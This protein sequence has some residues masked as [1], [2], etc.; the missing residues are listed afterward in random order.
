[1]KPAHQAYGLSS[2]TMILG[3]TQRRLHFLRLTLVFFALVNVAAH[4][5]ASPGST[6]IV[7]YWID[8]AS[9]CSIVVVKELKWLS[10]DHRWGSGPLDVFLRVVNHDFR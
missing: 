2:Q 6:S 3:T 4:L 1:M 8:P 10:K 7:S 5:C 9:A